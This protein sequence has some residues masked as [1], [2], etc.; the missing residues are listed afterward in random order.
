MAPAVIEFMSVM[1][2]RKGGKRIGIINQR[3]S[4]LLAFKVKIP[5]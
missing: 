3:F 1:W 2:I 4:I 5:I